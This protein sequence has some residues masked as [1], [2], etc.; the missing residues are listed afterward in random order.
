M[1]E[2]HEYQTLAYALIRS[3]SD[4]VVSGEG[5]AQMALSN[6]KA[7]ARNEA[8]T[9]LGDCFDR[10]KHLLAALDSLK[11]LA[12]HE[13]IQSHIDLESLCMRI[14][15]RVSLQDLSL[16]CIRTYK[17]PNVIADEPSL[18]EALI[19]VMLAARR[20]QLSIETRG[21]VVYLRFLRKARTYDET[22]EKLL[23]STARLLVRIS[24]GRLH[25]SK[26]VISIRLPKA[27]QLNLAI[28]TPHV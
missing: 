20:A 5:F 6:K 21:G 28:D 12:A 23:L 8:L 4:G 17:S 15:E 7:Q 26:Q 18:H 16:K 2:A 27:N 11:L 22:L 3:I 14:A 25:S 9:R 24:D 19:I 10:Q 1:V 13:P